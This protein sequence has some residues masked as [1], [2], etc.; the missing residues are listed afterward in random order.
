MTRRQALEQ[1]IK[2]NRWGA[3]ILE[4]VR[5]AQ[6]RGWMIVGGSPFIDE[7]THTCCPLNTLRLDVGQGGDFQDAANTVL[8]WSLPKA[9]AFALSFDGVTD[10][11][12][13]VEEDAL[14]HFG[15]IELGRMFRELLDLEARLP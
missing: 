9:W 11:G 6:A 12:P 7:E 8:G 1:S 10:K 14:K 15:A 13:Y 2:R 3:I 4:A 5:A